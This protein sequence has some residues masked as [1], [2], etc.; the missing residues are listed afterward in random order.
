M[1]TKRIGFSTATVSG[2]IYVI[3]GRDATAPITP[4]PVV[5]A[6]DVYDPATNTWTS[7]PSLPIPAA[8]QMTITSNGKIYAIGGNGEFLPTNVVQEL[9]TET[10]TWTLKANMPD[11]RSSASVSVNNGLIYISGGGGAGIE[12]NSLLWYDPVADTWNAGS[13]MSQ[14]R[15]GAG[16]VAIDGQILVYGGHYTTYLQDGGYLKSL[17]AYDPLMDSWSSK[18]DGNPRRDFG[19]A[20]I[21]TSMYVFG[22]NN[23]QRALDWV[24]AYDAATDQ[25]ILRT[26]MPYSL[27]YVRAETIGNKVYIFDTNIT[28]EYTP[29]NDML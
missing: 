19:V 25:W 24:N 21:N 9:D 7:G 3:G 22:G 2:L 15:S 6:V 12:L 8:E 10:Q 4:K 20:V 14:S 18:A 11:A 28:L 23:V 27:N 26:S 13:P 29:S 17:E 16:G 1:P 5:S